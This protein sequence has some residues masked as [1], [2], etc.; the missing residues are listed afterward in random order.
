ME[1]IDLQGQE[2]EDVVKVFGKAIVKSKTSRSLLMAFGWVNVGLGLLGIPLPILP[3]TPFLLLAAYCFG[4]SSP[5]MLRW[6]LTNRMF[7]PYLVGYCSNRGIPRR[8]KGYILV[9]L[10]ATISCSALLATDKTWLRILLFAIAVGVTVHI[11]K[12]KTRKPEKKA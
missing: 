9:T 8:V 6:L 4:R 1:K 3:T 2:L 11:L 7:G 10:W 12:L 5:R